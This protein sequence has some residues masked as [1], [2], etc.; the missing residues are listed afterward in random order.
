MKYGKLVIGIFLAGIGALLL[1]GAL[2]YLPPGVWPWLVKFWPL[3]LLALGVA[4][5]ANR[6]KSV[7][8]GTVAVALVIGSLGF[9]IYWISRH[10]DAAKTE[11]R[12]TIDLQKPPVQ[13][14]TLLSRAIA[15]SITLDADPTAKGVAL[16]DVHGV[17]DPEFA[18]HAWSVTRGAGLLEWPV[19]AKLTDAGLVGGSIRVRAPEQMPTRVQADALFSSAR[20]DLSGLKP[21]Q[22]DVHAIGSV[23]RLNVG[24]ARPPR[25][26]VH[27]WF[28]DVEIRLPANCPAQIE[29]TSRWTLR[30]YPDDFV[31][32]VTTYAKGK[33]SNWVAEGPGRPVPI[34]IDGPLM[35]VRIVRDP[36]KAL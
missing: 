15:G 29:C 6:L 3:V 18:A 19:R 13:A 9:G 14:I 27:G 23:V 35:R 26:R 34:T 10:S 17:S 22:C 7:V 31:E 8:I 11:H 24:A 20:I 32:Q 5:L 4:L 36:V 12:T 25:I 1:A 28:S 30:S 33:V 16:L 2:G 21:A